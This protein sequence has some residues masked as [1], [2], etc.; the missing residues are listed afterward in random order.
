ML[1]HETGASRT[2][3]GAGSL[4]GGRMLAVVATVYGSISALAALLQARQLV[5]RGRSCDLS[6]L[7][8]VIYLGGY[9]VWLAYGLS[10]ESTPIVVVNAIGLVSVASVVA[11]ALSLRGSLWQPRSWRSCPI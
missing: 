7:L 11:I 10:I 9:A 3:D 2:A 8:F 5:A 1:V 6:A 4:Y